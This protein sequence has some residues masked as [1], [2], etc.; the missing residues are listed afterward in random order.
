MPA[1]CVVGSVVE[2]ITFRVYRRAKMSVKQVRPE[3]VNVE[4]RR[5]AQKIVKIAAG[6]QERNGAQPPRF[7]SGHSQHAGTRARAAA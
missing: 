5:L 7:V 3:R 4:A 2:E 1:D 6:E